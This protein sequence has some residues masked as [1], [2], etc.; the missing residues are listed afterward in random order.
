LI[1]YFSEEIKSV[2]SKSKL[3]RN[4]PKK[5]GN[6]ELLANGKDDSI[7]NATT[8]AKSTNLD[9]QFLMNNVDE[10]SFYMKSD[11]NYCYYC[12]YCDDDI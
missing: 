4:P 12:D 10:G 3:D 9:G 1:L 5:K 11:E 2:P 8:D 6:P 7:F